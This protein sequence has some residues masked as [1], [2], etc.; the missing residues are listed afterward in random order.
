[1]ASSKRP[2]FWSARPRF[3]SASIEVPLTLDSFRQKA[4]GLDVPAAL[5]MDEAGQ[6]QRVEIVAAIF[7]YCGTQPFGLV[8][9][10]LL[11]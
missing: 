6:M 2:A 9:M 11:E 5:Q 4:D 3:D 7:P 1:M 10:T 8:E